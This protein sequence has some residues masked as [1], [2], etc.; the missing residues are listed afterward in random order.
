MELFKSPKL[1][2][3][4]NVFYPEDYWLCSRA[5]FGFYFH[6]PN[7]QKDFELGPLGLESRAKGQI[8]S[9]RHRLRSQMIERRSFRVMR[10]LPNSHS[11]GRKFA[12]RRLVATRFKVKNALIGLFDAICR[13]MRMRCE[14]DF[15]LFFASIRFLLLENRKF[16][17]ASHFYFLRC[18]DSI[19]IILFLK[20]GS[21]RL[22]SIRIRKKVPSPITGQVRVNRFNAYRF[23]GSWRDGFRLD[24]GRFGLHIFAVKRILFLLNLFQAFCIC[25]SYKK[26]IWKFL[27]TSY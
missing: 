2:Q 3:K 16:R 8:G 27:T 18:V 13:F 23:A 22:D 17:I 6:L 20:N 21:H 5:V 9:A 7:G 11:V 14:F 25:K 19:C 15:F 4:F 10:P 24:S 1:Q 26:F 12:Y